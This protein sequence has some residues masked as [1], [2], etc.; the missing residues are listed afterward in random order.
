M[1]EFGGGER[2]QGVRFLLRG[3]ALGVLVNDRNRNYQSQGGEK[4]LE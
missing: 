1:Q 3:Y 2:E 4:K